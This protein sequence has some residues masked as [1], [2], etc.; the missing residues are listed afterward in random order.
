MQT[1]NTFIFTII[2][3]LL[4]GVSYL[5]EAGARQIS[6]KEKIEFLISYVESL[7]GAVFIRNGKSHTP[8]EAAGHLRTKLR[9]SRRCMSTAE[10]FIKLCASQSS[11]TGRNYIIRFSDGRSYEAGSYLRKVLDELENGKDVISE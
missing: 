5:P 6:E 10:D 3:M 2:L 7:P 8:A 11:I 9:S 4:T 1:G